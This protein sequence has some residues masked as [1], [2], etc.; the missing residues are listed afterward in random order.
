VR[1][2]KGETLTAEEIFEHCQGI[3]SYKRPQHVEVWPEDKDFPLTRVAKVDKKEL[4]VVAE[5]IVEELRQ[6]GKWDAS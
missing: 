2:K 4:K 1:P 5:S 3:A 6:A